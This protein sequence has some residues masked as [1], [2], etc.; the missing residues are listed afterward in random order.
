MHKAFSAPLHVQDAALEIMGKARSAGEWL[1]M[2]WRARIIEHVQ[3]LLDGKAVDT[4]QQ[5]WVESQFRALALSR[6]GELVAEVMTAI[7]LAQG[8]DERKFTHAAAAILRREITTFS[9][10]MRRSHPNPVNI[11]SSQLC[12][13]VLLN[14]TGTS[15][16]QRTIVAVAEHC[17]GRA[18][19]PHLQRLRR[20]PVLGFCFLGSSEGIQDNS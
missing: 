17:C 19:Y 20:N 6:I 8:A 2:F 3:V 13:A 15:S 10:A 1:D 16:H 9:T 7:R 4:V 5:L 14:S 12:P 18:A 11:Y